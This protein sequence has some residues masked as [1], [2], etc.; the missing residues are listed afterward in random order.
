MHRTAVSAGQPG[1]AGTDHSDAFAGGGGALEGV[2]AEVRVVDGVTLQQADQ[3]RCA[4][5]VVVAHA[6]LLAEDF[7]RAHPCATAAEDVRREDFL[8]GA[9]DV[10][11]MDV[12][13]E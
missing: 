1:R 4:L 3:Y 5:V 11:L 8:R 2:F 12:A 13:D 9:L 7:R 10:V 6:G